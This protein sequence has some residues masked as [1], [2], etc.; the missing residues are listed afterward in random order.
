MLKPLG[1][2]VIGVGIYGRCHVRAY[3]NHPDTELVAIWS[4]TE[5]RARAV[6]DEAGCD[7]AT[8]L[9]RI[10]GDPRVRLVSVATPDFAHTIPTLKMLEAGKH[11]LLEKPMAYSVAEC[12]Q[13]IGAARESGVQLMVNFHNR[14]YP[15]IA[16]AQQMIVA[17]RIGKPVLA[18]LRLSDRIEVATRWLTWAG[19]SGPEWFLMPHTVDLV[20]FLMGQEVRRVSAIGRKGVLAARGLDCYDS[21]QA[22]LALDDGVATVES[23]WIL[24]ERWRNVIRMDI[25]IQGTEG[26]LELTA[27]HEGMTLTTGKGLE[28]PFFLDPTTTEWL[29]IKAFIESVRDDLPVPVPGEEGLACTAVLEAVARSLRTGQPADVEPI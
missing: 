14:Y 7:W 1:A 29:P 5:A 19:H 12:R 10:A 17:G 4:R 25:D 27:D 9:D 26:M 18:F 3:R 13:M 24:P 11:V 6:A 8:D 16:S 21:V 15:S 20:R 28:T 23:S 2:A 22:Q